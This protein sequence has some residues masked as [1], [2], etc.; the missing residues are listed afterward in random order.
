MKPKALF[1]GVDL[2]HVLF[3]SLSVLL[4]HDKMQ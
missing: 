4:E 1:G 2:S 3:L